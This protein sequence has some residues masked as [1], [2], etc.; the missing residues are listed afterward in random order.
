MLS[1]SI[2]NSDVNKFVEE[3]IELTG[4]SG[5]VIDY[6]QQAMSYMDR[7]YKKSLEMQTEISLNRQSKR[8]E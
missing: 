4:T 2:E 7:L 3:N 8:A 1:T 6:F 5:Q